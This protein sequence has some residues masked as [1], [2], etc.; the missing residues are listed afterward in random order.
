MCVSLNY[1]NLDLSMI[2]SRCLFEVVNVVWF[3]I[4]LSCLC[5]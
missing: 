1:L 2:Q 3:E 5:F 4:D